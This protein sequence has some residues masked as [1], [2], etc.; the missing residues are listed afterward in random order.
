MDIFPGRSGV[1]VPAIVVAPHVHEW[2]PKPV[3]QRLEIIRREIAAGHEEAYVP[4]ALGES[5]RQEPLIDFVAD[6]QD[7]D[8]SRPLFARRKSP[9]D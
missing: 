2:K 7:G 1:A 6:R 8:T 9:P 4:E 3:H 5:V